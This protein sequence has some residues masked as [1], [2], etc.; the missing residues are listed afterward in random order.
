MV[1]A[2]NA[3]ENS[4]AS[5]GFLTLS[6]YSFVDQILQTIKI[7]HIVSILGQSDELPWPNVG[8]RK[9]L[10][11]QYDDTTYSSAGFVAPAR[12]DISELILFA[13][14]WGGRS[15]LL[16]HCRAGTSRSPAAAMVCLAAIGRTDLIMPLLSRKAYYKPHAKTL[17]IYD[18]VSGSKEGLSS[19]VLVRPALGHVD[20]LSPATVLI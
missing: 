5:H 3:R 2:P 10:R 19:I 13:K 15:G 8:A 14:S 1:S 16:V 6:P 12:G 18:A 4:N 9:V 20:D 7:T 17:R 11:L